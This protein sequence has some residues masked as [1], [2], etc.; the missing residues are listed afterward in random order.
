MAKSSPK[1]KK[2]GNASLKPA[3]EAP[4]RSKSQ[5]PQKIEEV[6]SGLKSDELQE[7]QTGLKY[8]FRYLTSFLSIVLIVVGLYF[9]LN[10][11]FSLAVKEPI[12]DNTNNEVVTIDGTIDGTGALIGTLPDGDVDGN[13]DGKINEGSSTGRVDA[14]TLSAKEKSDENM[15]RIKQTGRWTATDYFHGDIGIGE[16]EV[17]LGDTLW[18][19]SE[20]VYGSGFEWHKILD[21]NSKS[22]GY[23]PNGSQALI[24]PGQILKIYK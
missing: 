11:L 19:I 17:K 7:F 4:I 2:P 16:Y 20:A 21:A 5:K 18:E 14:L 13:T 12:T 10:G 23:L 22:I 24:I 6:P 1:A 15:S 3:S 8:K 9:L